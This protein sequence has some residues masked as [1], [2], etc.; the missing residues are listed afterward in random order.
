MGYRTIIGLEIHSELMTDTK[1][2]CSCPN[3]FGGE[4]NTHCCPTCMGLPGSMPRINKRAVEFAIRAG[5]AFNCDINKETRMDR[6]HYHYVDLTKGF[7][8]SQ[9]DIP[10]CSNGYVEIE[11]E[12][13]EKKISLERIHIEEDTGKLNHSGEEETLVDYNRAGVPLIEIV[14]RPDMSS[15][16]EARLFL[17]NLRARLKYIEV[18]DCKMEQGS[19]R[20]D[21]NIN[22]V[23]EETGERSNISEI[24]NLNSFRA[25]VR[26]IEAEEKRHRELLEKGENTIAD[27]RRW[28]ETVGETISMREKKDADYRYI[29]DA[30]IAL[31]NIEDEWIKEIEENL[32]EL[33]HHKKERFMKEYG[34]SEYDAEVLTQ[35]RDLARFYEE[36]TG[37]IDDYEMVS[38]WIMGDVLRRLNDELLEIE[39]TP[40]TSKYL[41]DLLQMIIDEK[42]S[43]NI[44]KKV[45]RK[46]FEEGKDPE[47]IVKDEGWVQISDEGA[48]LEMIDEVL[49]ANPQSIEDFKAGKDRALGFL[50]GQ[51]MKI[52][53]GKANPQLVN[54]KLTEILKTK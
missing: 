1:M 51:V 40:L 5:L 20:C 7:Q 36:T 19:L 17:E 29:A 2:F 22:I 50:V 45:L 8:T 41:A 42:I 4:A 28:D 49:E 33:P 46:I 43:N 21:V 39:E 37:Y 35:S 48:L 52:S 14:T 24:K 53:R 31:I 54:E 34:L 44:G 26:S 3:E 15:A 30:D 16:E 10:L 6:K 9:D 25:V 27:T 47:S 12:D 11:T 23:N 18:S 38:N 13:G 32:P